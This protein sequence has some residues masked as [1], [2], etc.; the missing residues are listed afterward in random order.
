MSSIGRIIFL[1]VLLIF[2]SA[3]SIKFKANTAKNR[4]FPD[5]ILGDFKY[6]SSDQNGKREWELR[7][8]EAKMFNARNQVFLYNMGMTFFNPD[9]SVKSYLSANSGFI[10]KDSMDVYAEGKVRIY[11]ENQ[12]LLEA[13][14]VYWDNQKKLFYS[15][16]Q[17]LVSLRRG[18]SV[19]TGYKMVADAELKE[20]SLEHSI[21]SGK[22]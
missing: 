17:E 21:G 19:V 1:L 6:T 14:K 12:A 8:S 13:N 15:E 16:P 18:N 5:I 10:N 4:E 2:S 3:C 20:V 7:A 9:N 22:K 11:S